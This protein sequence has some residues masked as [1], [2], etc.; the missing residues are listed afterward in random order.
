MDEA[1]ERLIEQCAAQQQWCAALGSALYARVLG[2]IVDELRAGGPIWTL[3]APHAGDPV[4]SVLPL[5]FLG[6][7]HRLV[8]SGKAPA[9][10]AHYPSAGG[11]MD[12]ATVWDAFRQTV[13]AHAT[14]LAVRVRDGVQTNEVG[15][16]AALIC[17]FLTVARETGL[18]LRIL[19]VGASAGLNLR[20][21]RFRYETE[22]GGFG[23]PSSP[24]R[25]DGVYVPGGAP[26]FDGAPIDVVSRL[27]CD[28]APLDPTT[29]AGGE[30]LLAYVWPDQM[31][32]IERLRGA[33]ALAQRVPAVVERCG[34]GEWLARQ[35]ATPAPGVATVVYHSI[36]LQ[37]VAP[38]ERD[39]MRAAIAAAGARADRTAP[40]AWLCM[41]PGGEQAE[42]HLTSWPGGEDRLIATTGF[43]GQTVRW[44]GP[45]PLPSP[46]VAR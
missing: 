9:L 7:V 5:R 33:L 28:P 10:A 39:A 23:D 45:N 14:E 8:L 24:V 26:P 29:A 12:A 19:E 34:A 30:T 6:A 37:Y 2:G 44:L 18:P 27:G 15:R 46:A 25:L 4:S 17:G 40:F 35:L 42:V 20:F 13:D 36:M 31:T 41:E 11:H 16:A 21:D 1:R 3:L 38:D 43:H 22:S 32:R